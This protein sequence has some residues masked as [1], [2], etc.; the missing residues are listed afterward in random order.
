MFLHQLCFNNYSF[1]VGLSAFQS[2]AAFLYALLVTNMTPIHDKQNKLQYRRHKIMDEKFIGYLYRYAWKDIFG[3]KR[4]M[5]DGLEVDYRKLQRVFQKLDHQKGAS[6]VT[7]FLF[8]YLCENE[9]SINGIYDRYLLDLPKKGILLWN[10]YSSLRKS[11]KR[12]ERL[13]SMR[14]IIIWPGSEFSFGSTGMYTSSG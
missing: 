2:Q 5:A 4:K 3:S 13:L 9:V 7:I 12:M 11:R 6:L 8:L 10:T 1:S 14:R